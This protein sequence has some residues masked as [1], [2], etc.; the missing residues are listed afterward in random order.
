MCLSPFLSLYPDPTEVFGLNRRGWEL[1]IR[2]AR[3]QVRKLLNESPSL[4]RKTVELYVDAYESGRNAA[5]I[6]L[7]LPEAALPE[8]SP[9]SLEQILDVSFLPNSHAKEI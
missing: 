1:T 6:A 3:H 7:K 4:R 9:W 8:A 2:E 5:L